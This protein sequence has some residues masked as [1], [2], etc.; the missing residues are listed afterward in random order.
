MSNRPI[1]Y[2]ADHNRSG[3]ALFTRRDDARAWMEEQTRYHHP[4]QTAR[5]VDGG[6]HGW[7]AHRLGDGTTAGT[8]Y[9][10]QL[11]RALPDYDADDWD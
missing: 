1:Q 11:D 6:E 7:Q 10:L 9:A 5:W 8:M 4:D 3:R 2:L